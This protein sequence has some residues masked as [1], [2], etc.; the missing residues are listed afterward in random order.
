MKLLN[1]LLLLLITILVQPAIADNFYWVNGSGN[2]NDPSHWSFKENGQGGTKIPTINDQV[3]FTRFSFSSKQD[4]ISIPETASCAGFTWTDKALGILSRNSS[5]KLIVSEKLIISENLNNHF[6]GDVIIDPFQDYFTVS[7]GCPLHSNIIVNGKNKKIHLQNN[8][9]TSGSFILKDNFVNNHGFTL[10]CNNYQEIS[11]ENFLNENSLSLFK[12]AEKGAFTISVSSTNVSCYGKCDGT[13]T[14]TLNGTP[15]YN[16]N[17]KLYLPVELG[18]GTL[19]FNNLSA[20]DFPYTIG[21]LC[22]AVAAYS[23]RVRD[24]DNSTQWGSAFVNA[25]G[26]MIIADADTTHETCPGDCDAGVTINFVQNA[27]YPI[28][29]Q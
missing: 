13:I 23:V 24:A 16:I 14:I 9:I 8:L 20:G 12:N 7:V 15:T 1:I 28:G 29:Y 4:I 19:D 6:L 21:N 10:S 18:G 27:I 25:P 3:F 17:I 22:G 2:W 26:Q 11:K 5:T